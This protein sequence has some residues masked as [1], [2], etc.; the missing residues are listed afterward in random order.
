MSTLGFDLRARQEAKDS[1][2]AKPLAPAPLAAA[3]VQGL[4]GRLPDFF[5]VGQPKS[6]T[7]ALY[8][9]L[10]GHPQIYMPDSKEP[11]FFASELHVRTPPRPGGTPQTLAEYISLFKAARPEQCVG[12][13]SALYLWSRTAAKR[14]AE[15]QPA[16]RII[17]ILREP[18]SLLRSLH[19]QF[20]QT[21]VETENDLRKALA[22]EDSRREGKRIPRYSY[23]P[24]A[25]LY[26]EHVRYVEQLRRYRA[27]LPPER[28]LVLIYDDFK[29]DNE[30]TVR[31][32]LRFLEVDDTVEIASSEANPTV[33]ARSQGLLE[34]L[35]AVSVGRGPVS[36]AF[37]AAV[38]S[39]V[40]RDLRRNALHATQ[41][42]V[43]FT[44]PGPPDRQLMAQLRHRYRR[45]VVALSDYLGRDLVSLWGCEDGG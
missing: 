36:L 26:S 4:P 19:L 3:R 39:V 34:L 32:V 33:R 17:A 10:R 12:E 1:T 28:I 25:L 5:I 8:E 38:K 15:V 45:E 31:A 35:H 16:A 22:L 30:G 37:K 41:R 18:A 7:T 13:A 20:V 11:W 9:M 27:V 23:W 29:H 6:G 44:E 24:D 14:I 43:V 42:R 2:A 21:Y 40:P